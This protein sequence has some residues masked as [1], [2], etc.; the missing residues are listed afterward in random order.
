M[1]RNQVI[2]FEHQSILSAVFVSRFV[3]RAIL[4]LNSLF[5]FLVFIKLYSVSL[6]NLHFVVGSQPKEILVSLYKKY[7]M[8]LRQ[9]IHKILQVYLVLIL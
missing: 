7:P 1:F 9:A 2:L 3:F 6:C 5:F 8:E 4:F